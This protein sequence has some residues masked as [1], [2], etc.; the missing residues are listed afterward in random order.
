[1]PGDC[2]KAFQLKECEDGERYSAGQTFWVGADSPP[3][4]ELERLAKGIF[5]LHT[6]HAHFDPATSGAEWWTQYIDTVDDI[7][8]HFDRDVSES[9]E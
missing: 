4:C 2:K 7:G 3:R 9:R 6:Q 1:M 8:F 5:A